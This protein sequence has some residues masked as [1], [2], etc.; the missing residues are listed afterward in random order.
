MCT[1][2]KQIYELD[3]ERLKQKTEYVLM[4]MNVKLPEGLTFKEI[5]GC[6]LLFFLTL[7]IPHSTHFPQF[8]DSSRVK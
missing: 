4:R 7:V 5:V 2:E 3:L 8:L 6:S 1:I